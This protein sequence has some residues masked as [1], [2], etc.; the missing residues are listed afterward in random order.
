MVF[1]K[2]KAIISEEL[3]NKVQEIK[4]KNTKCRKR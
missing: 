3:Y 1:E 4:A 2:V